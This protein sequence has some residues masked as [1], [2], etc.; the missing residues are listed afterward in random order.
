M[1]RSKT[2]SRIARRDFLKTAGTVGAGLALTGAAPHVRLKPYAGQSL[3]IY[4]QASPI[5][6]GAFH[7]FRPYFEE[8]TGAKIK[9][10]SIPV[11]DMGQQI[12]LSLTADTGEM[13]VTWYYA[14]Y[15]LILQG[16][17]EPIDGFIADAALTPPEWNFADY[18][19]GPLDSGRV[20][21]KLYNLSVTANALALYYRTDKIA[22]AGFVDS[23]GA[24]R[25]PHSWDQVK[26]YGAAMDAR[27]DKPLLL[28]YST[29]GNQM[30]LLWLSLWLAQDYRYIW[31]ANG[32][33]MVNQADGVAVTRLMKEL[34]QW[35]SPTSLTWDFPEGHAAFQQGRGALFPQWNNL[36]GIYDD[37]KNSLAA[38]K[39]S[40]AVW[41][42]LRVSASDSGHWYSLIAANSAH[43]ELAW[44][45]VREYN[46]FAWQKKFFLDSAVNFNPSRSSVYDDP[47]VV[48]AY[49][50][51][52]AI[53][54]SNNNGRGQQRQ[55]LEWDEIDLV[56][57]EE[58]GA[59][60]ADETDDVQHVLDRIAGGVDQICRASGRLQG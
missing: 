28:M 7:L 48:E 4:Q 11:A 5:F 6:E 21:G 60:I 47:E 13:D 3:T 55:T 27:R 53:R 46:S 15:P 44:V 45:L 29:S 37:A 38:G 12:A 43:K 2:A 41:P 18:L 31:D 24:A 58:L 57:K 34:L 17:V 35:A 10:V 54:A 52:G 23:T 16:L 51:I 32:R 8:L 26:Q 59:Y 30:N 22:Q 9:F 42:K 50:W 56:L 20:D 33:C 1:P 39:F 40:M 25:P 49:P 36:G 14:V 19:P